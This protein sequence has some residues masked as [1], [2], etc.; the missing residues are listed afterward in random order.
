[1]L[2]F[3]SFRGILQVVEFHP[4]MEYHMIKRSRQKFTKRFNFLLTEA[5]QTDLY[6]IAE[7]ADTEAAEVVRRMIVRETPFF[8][9]YASEYKSLPSSETKAV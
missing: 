8:L 2:T 3:A 7:L 1:V 6:T 9:T 4:P 5:M